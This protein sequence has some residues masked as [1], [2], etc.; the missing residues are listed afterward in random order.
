MLN[1]EKYKFERW[2]KRQE[3]HLK[4]ADISNHLKFLKEK[5]MFPYLETKLP[6]YFYDA[7]N[8]NFLSKEEMCKL[9]SW[10]INQ[11]QIQYLTKKSKTQSRQGVRYELIHPNLGL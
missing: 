3:K 5:G 7:I 1:L 4:K 9:Q 2:K 6:K 8:N 11:A 10:E